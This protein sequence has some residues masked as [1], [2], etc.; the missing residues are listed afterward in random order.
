MKR[1]IKDYLYFNKQER[2]AVLILLALMGLFL[3]LPYWY[4]PGFDPPVINQALADWLTTDNDSSTN[5]NSIAGTPLANTTTLFP[6]DPNTITKADW[7]RLGL[8]AKTVRTILNYRSKGG[9]FRKQ[10][11]LKKIWGMSA[12]DAERLIPFVRIAGTEI[13]KDN[14]TEKYFADRVATRKEPAMID[15]NTAGVTEWISLPGIGEV[16]ANRITRYRDKIG[17]FHSVQQVGKTYGIS[18]SLF[19]AIQRYLQYDTGTLPK[20]NLNTVSAYALSQA[21]FDYHFARELVKYR[22]Q[23]GPYKSMDELHKLVSAPDSVWQKLVTRIK[24]E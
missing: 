3:V 13:V 21:G 15:I 2:I 17:G 8:S 1:I 10:D 23:N 20:M 18:D 6:F 24:I 22:E 9:K 14:R 16:L 7:L 19:T 12:T 11:D 5:E 4:K